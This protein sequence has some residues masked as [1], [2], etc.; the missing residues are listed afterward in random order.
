MA[1]AQAEHTDALRAWM[2][3][4]G[5]DE[6]AALARLDQARAAVRDAFDRTAR[7]WQR[8]PAGWW[9]PDATR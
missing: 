1:A 3:A 8:S 5:D 6:P 9:A 2:L 7:T 4:R